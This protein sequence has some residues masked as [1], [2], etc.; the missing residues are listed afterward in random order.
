MVLSDS[1][2]IKLIDNKSIEYY[3]PDFINP[4]SIDLTLNKTCKVYTKEA[5]PKPLHYFNHNHPFIDEWL[6][7]ENPDHLDCKEHNRTLKFDIPEEGFILLP[8]H[9]YL[10][11]CNEKIKVPN[12]LCA[13][14][15]GK[16]S[17]GRLG[18][19]IHITAGFLDP[20]FEGSLVLE[21]ETIYPIKIYPDM[22]I[23]QIKYSTLKGDVLVQYGAR[24]DSKY[25]NQEGVVESLMYKNFT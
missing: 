22:R 15:D 1:E 21:V 11:S 12:N 24:K 18:V 25:M 23:C 9:L 7:F 3:H 6:K 2:L 8:G 10:F 17:I 5:I 4:S 13:E 20:G 14:V 16:S 19:K